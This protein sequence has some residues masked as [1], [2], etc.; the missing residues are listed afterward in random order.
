M[1]HYSNEAYKSS[2]E[3][4]YLPQGD[5]VLINTWQYSSA[6]TWSNSAAGTNKYA[7]VITLHVIHGSQAQHSPH[8]LKWR[9]WSKNL[10]LFTPYEFYLFFFFTQ[11]F[12]HL[13]PATHRYRF[14]LSLVTIILSIQTLPSFC[15]LL[16]PLTDGLTKAPGSTF[17]LIEWL[18]EK[19]SESKW[20]HFCQVVAK[21]N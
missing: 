14:L 1:A 15:S 5:W 13:K 4:N 19:L 2:F 3:L 11:C 21:S 7:S 16:A 9:D 8:Y 18:C 17:W 10:C 12:S 20:T 6:S